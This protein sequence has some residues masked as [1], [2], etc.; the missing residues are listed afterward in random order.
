MSTMG[1]LKIPT[2]YIIAMWFIVVFCVSVGGGVYISFLF[3]IFGSMFSGCFWMC[4]GG[5]LFFSLVFHLCLFLF[6]LLVLD[7][8]GKLLARIRVKEEKPH[9]PLNNFR[10]RLQFLPVCQLMAAFP[11]LVGFLDFP[12]WFGYFYNE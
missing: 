1:W 5:L 8:L 11:V 10:G 4:D 7:W 6:R 2:A 9:G 3:Y 12:G